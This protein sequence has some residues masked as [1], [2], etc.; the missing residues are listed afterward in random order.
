MVAAPQELGATHDVLARATDKQ[1]VRAYNAGSSRAF[2]EIVE[3]HRLRLTYVARRYADNEHDAQDILQDA[4]FKASRNL[5]GFRNEASLSTWLHRLVMNSGHDYIKHKRRMSY[6]SL[7][8]ADKV[9]PDSNPLLAHD[10]TA[11]VERQIMLRQVLGRLPETQRRA[12]LLL[13]VA[14][15]TV[16]KAAQEMGVRPGTVKSRRNRARTALKG[17]IRDTE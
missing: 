5:H 11:S 4:L 6:L 8:D 15:L 1:L 2:D 7:D 3:R 13:D 12:I 10:P 17:H 16:E 9:N 14:G